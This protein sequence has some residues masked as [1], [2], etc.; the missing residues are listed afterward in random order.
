MPAEDEPGSISEAQ[1][2]KLH[3]VLTGLGFG[4]GDR[5]QKLVIA[6]TIIGRAPL[7]GPAAGRSS[8]NLSLTEAR[9]L[10]DALDGFA[11]R[12][13]LI[14]YMAEHEDYVRQEASGE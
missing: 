2:T 6:E 7:H 11:D 9:G 5:D 14:A 1:L 8:K 4:F 13:A 3:T 12:D 10:I